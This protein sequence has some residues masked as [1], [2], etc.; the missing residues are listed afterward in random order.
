MRRRQLII[1]A[2]ALFTVLPACA[3]ADY[4]ELRARAARDG[5]VRVIVTLAIA[6]GQPP[7]DDAIRDAQERLIAALR[8]TRYADLRRFRSLPQLALTAGPDALEVLL[9]SPLVASIAADS[10][11]HPMGPGSR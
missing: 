5:A 4:G 9:A 10:L 2:G 7:T 1:A 6:G 8:G 11:A 3:S